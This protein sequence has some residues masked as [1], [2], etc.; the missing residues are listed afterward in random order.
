MRLRRIC[1]DCGFWFS[2]NSCWECGEPLCGICAD[3]PSPYLYSPGK[4]LCEACRHEPLTKV[5][6]LAVVLDHTDD[7]SGSAWTPQ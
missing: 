7:Y 6:G 1:V 5:Q 4:G 3:W 2:F